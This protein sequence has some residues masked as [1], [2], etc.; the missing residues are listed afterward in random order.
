MQEV[1]D[2]HGSRAP[3]LTPHA[4]YPLP[5][6]SEVERLLAAA[7]RQISVIAVGCIIGLILGDRNSYLTQDPDWTPTY[8]AGD[9]FG[10][11]DLLRSADVVAELP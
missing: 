11:T 5:E 3:A 2:R 6:R 4:S 10:I 7:R 9:T 8:G 1:V